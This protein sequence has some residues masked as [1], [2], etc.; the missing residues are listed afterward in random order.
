MWLLNMRGRCR[1]SEYAAV[2]EDFDGKHQRQRAVLARL[3]PQSLVDA[4]AKQAQEA[5]ASADSI[6]ASVGWI[7]LDQVA[8]SSPVHGCP[9]HPGSQFRCVLSKQSCD[10]AAS[11]R[12]PGC[13][14]SGQLLGFDLA[15]LQALEV[16]PDHILACLP[17]GEQVPMSS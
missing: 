13:W 11:W 2:K 17:M 3:E 10:C 15:H 16:S 14:R 7:R 4:L 5:E 9:L 12:Q 1:G 6:Q 8:V